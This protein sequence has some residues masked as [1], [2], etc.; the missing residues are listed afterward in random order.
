[1]KRVF[2]EWQHPRD[3][4]GRFSRKGGEAWAKRAAE[5][6]AAYAERTP[7]TLSAPG[8]P[9]IGAKTK[10]NVI[11]DEHLGRKNVARP[12]P[13]MPE[14]PGATPR[15]LQ[16]IRDSDKLLQVHH[17]GGWRKVI[18]HGHGG[19]S[20][21]VLLAGDD[22][23]EKLQVPMVAGATLP[24][25]LYKQE[26]HEPLRPKQAERMA[27]WKADAAKQ[28]PLRQ[29]TRNEENLADAQREIDEFTAAVKEAQRKARARANRKYPAKE[30]YG[31]STRD[32]YVRY[33]RQVGQAEHDLML[34][35]ARLEYM[36]AA[37]PDRFSTQPG[38]NLPQ[39]TGPLDESRPL[40][41]YGNLLNIE[42]E[43]QGTYRHVADLATLPAALHAIVAKHMFNSRVRREHYAAGG[44]DPGAKAG[45]FLGSKPISQL[46]ESQDLQQEQPRGWGEGDT[47]D[48]VDGA[49]RP[50][51]RTLLVGVSVKSQHRGEHHQPALHEFGHALD[52]AVGAALGKGA[53]YSASEGDDWRKI[54]REA[55]DASPKMS[56]YFKQDGDA[57]P[58][59]MW[60]EGFGAWARARARSRQDGQQPGRA[61]MFALILALK[62]DSSRK[63]IAET[64]SK[65]FEGL[66][67]QLGVD[68]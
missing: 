57:G 53:A 10:A 67:K 68:L 47:F 22:T 36:K 45:I 24:T 48:L 61:G 4:R 32:D 29:Q 33:D 14:I 59:E 50:S 55:V 1:M 31:K 34:A 39:L 37:P 42:D 17:E 15:T 13:K 51:T 11:I 6:F 7:R 64:M 3:E 35:N 5:Q 38:Y 66:T 8:R 16:E 43:D 52:R 30:G 63:D 18:G 9:R 28:P 27:R 44:P 40:A 56:P 46:D 62:I 54:W 60:A 26:F 58:A 12:K 25:R 20:D 21:H 23:G 2:R 65:Y 49:Y 19:G 41:V